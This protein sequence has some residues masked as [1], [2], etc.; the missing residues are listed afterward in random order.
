MREAFLQSYGYYDKKDALL[1]LPELVKK[2]N[3]FFSAKTDTNLIP[4]L[5]RTTLASK[6]AGNAVTPT[7]SC[8]VIAL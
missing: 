8:N 1:V 4:I 5:L 6:I 3:S 7:F 2:D